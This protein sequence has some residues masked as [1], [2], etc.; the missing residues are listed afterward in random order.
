MTVN[1]I[2]SKSVLIIVNCGIYSFKFFTTINIKYTQDFYNVNLSTFLNSVNNFC[3]F[4][5]LKM[6]YFVQIYKYLLINFNTYI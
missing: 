2:I 4:F 6:I 3:N 1:I 5:F